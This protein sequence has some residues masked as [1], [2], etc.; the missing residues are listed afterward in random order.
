MRRQLRFPHPYFSSH[1]G[2]KW[3]ILATVLMGAAMS[4]LDVSIVNVA[5]PTLKTQFHVSMPVIEWITMAYMLALTVF[6]PLFGRLSD[7]YGRS[8]LYNAGFLVFATGSLLCG[9]S[10]SAALLIASR[11]VQAVGAGLLQANSIAL[12]VQA[13]PAKERGKAIG[14]QGAV[15]AISM[16]LG[17][18]VGGLLI[19]TISWRAIFF[20]NIPI[21]VMGI[22]A[23]ILVLPAD[24][25][26]AAK[27][28]VDYSG[29]ILLASGLGFLMLAINE[30]VKLG[31][32]SGTILAYFLSSLVLLG[33]FIMRELKAANPLIDLKL[34]KNSS[35]LLGNLSSMFSY[36]VLFAMLFLMPFYL[37]K[38]LGY[39]VELTGFL[40]TPLL[41]AMAVVAPFSGHMSSKYGARIMTTLGMLVS[42]TACLFLLL[43]ESSGIPALVGV[44]IFLGVG[45]GL[46]TPSNNNA[47]MAAAPRDK[48]SVAGGI[49]N[50]MRSLGL[51]FGVNISG[52]IFTGL[53][54]R[55]LTEKGFP[56]AQHVFSNLSIPAGIKDNAFL[57]GFVVVLLVLV[58]LNLLSFI[59]SAA[60]KGGPSGVIDDEITPVVISSGFLTGLTREMEGKAVYVALL[61]FVGFM[62]TFA[63]EQ[64]RREGFR[65]ASGDVQSCYL[66][67]S[68]TGIPAKTPE[69]E[70]AKRLAL[71]YYADKYGDKDVSVE[72]RAAGD[73]M[74]A[75][76][77]K[78]EALVKKL[79]IRGNSVMEAKTGLRDTLYDFFVLVN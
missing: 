22:I 68:E 32:G 7:I 14:I 67:P 9:L 37:E 10:S 15:Q 4:A 57:H 30:V 12:V 2:W 45:M 29:A 43:G 17:P 5:M 26:S 6:L 62:G 13:F 11:V 38:A 36:Y 25:R 75:L 44:M 3:L 35:F 76:L 47:V 66:S 60:K 71:V 8:R 24:E 33:L 20:L 54:H 28:K 65:P 19:S 56:N 23:G 31:W 55:Y 58:L 39:G 72:V 49:L 40:L 48:L 16:A 51:I 27:E 52:M 34:L 53:E 61:L 78:D 18:F 63:T 77:F 1:P 59:F 79:E 21:G 69:S 46:F 50:M 74:E 64:L 41:L 73:H 70:A 42:A